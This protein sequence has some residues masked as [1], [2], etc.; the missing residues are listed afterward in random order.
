[1]RG[2]LGLTSAN[3]CFVNRVFISESPFFKMYGL[4][5]IVVEII[6]GIVSL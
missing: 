3:M 6:P 4:P 2:V 5:D 1:M